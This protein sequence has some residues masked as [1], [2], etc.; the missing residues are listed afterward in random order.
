MKP[1]N[2]WLRQHNPEIDEKYHQ[3][4]MFNILSCASFLDFLDMI[5]GVEGDIVECGIGRSRSLC[6]LRSLQLGLGLRRKLIAYDSFAG[7]PE[8]TEQDASAR[9][10]QA[11]D[12][13]RSPSGKY[14]Y[15]MEFC[16]QVLQEAHIP[17]DN[18][19]SFALVKGF[20]ADTLPHNAS[21]DIALLNIDGD[22]Y[23]S[24]KDCLRWLYHKIPGGG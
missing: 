6:I 19:E 1:L 5:N 24:Y 7:F 3:L 21:A 4:T 17:D 8:P 13:S 22:L 18:D 11:G 16:R 20:F 23:Q 12:W 14:R 2:T 9:N 15:D 10:P